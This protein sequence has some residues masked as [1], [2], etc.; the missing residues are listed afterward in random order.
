MA[1]TDVPVILIS[2]CL[3]N[4]HC[5][6]DGASKHRSEFDSALKTGRFLPLC[7][8]VAGGLGVPREPCEIVGGDG[9]DVLSGKAVVRARSGRDLTAEYI[10]GAEAVLAIAIRH[11]VTVAVLKQRSP[12]CGVGQLKSL[13]K[14]INPG[15]GVAAALLRRHGIEVISD[16]EWNSKIP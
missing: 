3:V 10:R 12:S 14:E 4:I 5:R 2:A 16:E 8:E 9:E 11:G 15:F 7:P 6:Y 13:A 1:T